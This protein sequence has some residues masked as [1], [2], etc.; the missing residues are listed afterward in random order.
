MTTD[1]SKFVPGRPELI[2]DIT[3]DENNLSEE[4]KR[5]FDYHTNILETFQQNHRHVLAN[6]QISSIGRYLVLIHLK[7]MYEIFKRVLNYGAN[8][9]E[10]LSENL[11]NVGP[12]IICGL[13]RTGSTL[14]YNLLACDPNCR[15]PLMTEMAV[16]CV[17]PMSRSDTV[18]CERR[19][20]ILEENAEMQNRLVGRS[21][22]FAASHPTFHIEEDCVFLW[23][24]GIWHRIAWITPLD[25]PEPSYLFYDK[26]K[27]DCA[28]T[29]HQTALRLLN[30]VDK[31]HSH[32]LL[33]AQ[34]HALY[35][36]ALLKQYPNA[37]LIMTHRCLNEAMPSFCRLVST[38]DYLFDKNNSKVPQILRTRAIEHF[39]KMVQSIVDFRKGDNDE[40]VEV[41][42]SLLD[43]FYDDLM[44]DPIGT[45]KQIYDH[46]GLQWSQEFEK[47]MEKWLRENPQGKQ[48][49]N[50]YSLSDFNL[51]EDDIYIRY[52]AYIDLFPRARR[53]SDAFANTKNNI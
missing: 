14:L 40:H 41:R 24:T 1:A 7:R 25:Q 28:Y 47:A 9:S 17:P 49:R 35:L 27:N 50:S 5:R 46:F 38:L 30:S 11:P 13:P 20:R 48:G 53:S 42:K 52:A 3:F 34:F 51:T 22:K 23:Q 39:D 18:E 12:V 44:D 10:I 43:I 8:H 29:Y 45:V 16:D 19:A 6:N 15:A 21:D 37:C 26:M 31:P 32:W 36:D 33:K 4:A 2:D